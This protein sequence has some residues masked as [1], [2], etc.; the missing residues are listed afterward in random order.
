MRVL[1]RRRVT[2][3]VEVAVAAQQF[4]IGVIGMGGI[5]RWQMSLFSKMPGVR[6]V[7]AADIT[8]AKLQQA[9]SEYGIESIY[10]DYRQ[11]LEQRADLD[12][13]SVCTP[14]SMHAEHS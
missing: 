10:T 6:I 14:N 3:R 12:A 1:Y 8:E 2:R 5:A 7:A 4:K 9:Q 11:M 13:V